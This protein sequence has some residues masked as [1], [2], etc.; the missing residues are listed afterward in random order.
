MSSNPL[1]QYP[2]AQACAGLD[3]AW[4]RVL[5][6]PA[7]A[8]DRAYLRGLEAM[9]WLPGAPLMLS[10]L[11]KV[12]PQGVTA[13]LMGESP[14]PRRQ[15]AIG[16]SFNDGAVGAIWGSAGLAKP[17]NKAT[18][19]RNIVK[20][21]LVAEGL[22]SPAATATEIAAVDRCDLVVSLEDLFVRIRAAGILCLNAIPVLT[23]NKARDARAWRGFMDLFLANL[24]R[25][26]PDATLLLFG[27]F[28]KDL[29]TVAGAA[30]WDTIAAEHPYNV[31]FINDAAVL[32]Y[33]RPLHLLRR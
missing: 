22:I 18:S 5:E 13:V 10:P 2:F 15:S 11:R 33:F 4:A 9:D 17:V 8:M 29:G 16:E 7:A 25:L 32:D 26:A 19:L 23:A 3:P 1:S 12:G 30:G 24:H 28:A 14:Y 27:N 20:M 21:L 31:S 6:A